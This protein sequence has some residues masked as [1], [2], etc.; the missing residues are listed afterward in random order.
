MATKSDK[1]AH[2]RGTDENA[3]PNSPQ[4]EIHASGEIG[5]WF[6]ANNVSL[7]ATA[8][9]SNLVYSFG[10]V[11]DG[12]LGCFYSTFPHPMAAA[13]SPRKDNLEVWLACRGFLVRCSDAGGIYN[14][15]SV[16][17]GGGG[18]FTSTLVSRQLHRVGKQDV[19]GVYPVDPDAP[20]FTSTAFSALC[21]LDPTKPDVTT[22]AV[23]KPSFITELR[24]EDRCHMN[25]VCFVNNVLTY[26]TCVC[27]SDA[28]DGWRDHR[29]SGG[30]VVDV[31][32][33]KIVARGLS[34]PHS[35]RWFRGELWVLNSGTG[36]LGVIDFTTEKFVPRV[37]IPGF[38]RGLQ[39]MGRYAVVGSSLDRHEKRFQELELGKR[40]EDKKTTP[41]CGFFVV[42]LGTNT[43]AHKVALVGNVH[44]IYDVILVP[45]R[46][47]RVIGLNDD[48][49]EVMYKVVD[50]CPVE[51][52]SDDEEDEK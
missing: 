22:S 19:H 24:A 1:P 42:D 27:E 2:L 41:V 10:A 48:E 23:W 51:E 35:P 26:A 14:E 28:H 12:R 5:K 49:A 34:M 11:D 13:L 43:I 50:N 8:Y 44:E 39:F 21:K 32:K 20:F 47:A 9:K 17:S 3:N 15:G 45:G 30:V 52:S 38:L 46:R 33:N 36:E 25:D 7:V 29:Q 6:A 16:Q 31:Q 18:D 40:L 4:F 37:F